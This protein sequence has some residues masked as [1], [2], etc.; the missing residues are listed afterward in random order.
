LVVVGHALDWMRARE[1]SWGID[2]GHTPLVLP[3]RGRRGMKC[4]CTG[5]SM[6]LIGAR[7]TAVLF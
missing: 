7:S 3:H 6:H 1:P 2:G 4:W 5:W